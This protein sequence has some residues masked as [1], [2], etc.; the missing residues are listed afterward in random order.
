[1]VEHN[2]LVLVLELAGLQGEGQGFVE[3]YE[4]IDAAQGDELA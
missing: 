1:M 2:A 4:P 3:L